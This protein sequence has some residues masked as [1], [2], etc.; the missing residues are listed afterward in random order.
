MRYL[1]VEKEFGLFLGVYRDIFIFAKNCIFPI[2][3]SP[4]FDTKKGAEYYIEKY[5]PK[6]Y[7]DYLVISIK[8]ENKYVHI[9]EVIKAGYK[10]YTHELIDFIP[11]QSEEVH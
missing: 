8:S 2:M 5:F 10:E 4:S 9:V 11:M 3:K 6:E 7:K 1:I